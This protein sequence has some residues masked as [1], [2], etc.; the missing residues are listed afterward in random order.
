MTAPA[1]GA[2][3]KRYHPALVTLHWLL[4]ILLSAALGSGAGVLSKLPNTSP[5]KIP[6]LRAH[7]IV[8]GLILGLTLLRLLARWMTAHP[9]PAGRAAAWVDRHAPTLQ[10]AFYLA[11]FAMVGSGAGIAFGAH[12]PEVVFGGVG[13]L[14]PDFSHIPARSAHGV[15]AKLLAGLI[16]LHVAAA[17]HHQLV[18]RDGLLSRMWFGRRH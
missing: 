6:A 1:A 7:M 17:L 11:V 3:V 2:P 8:G 16:V 9:P 13:S 14:P 15:V 4:A 5:D 12:L 10:R 18:L